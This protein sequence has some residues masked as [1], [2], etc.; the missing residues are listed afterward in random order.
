[1]WVRIPP[2]ALFDFLGWQV[3][4]YDRL[5]LG[6]ENTNDFFSKLRKP[7]FTKRLWKRI[8]SFFYHEQWIILLAK[9][10][11][12]RN[13]SWSDFTRIIPPPDRIWADPFI[14]TR[15][16]YYYIFFEEQPMDTKRGRICCL[17]LDNH[18]KIIANK[19]VLEQ[20][21]HLSYPF[22][23]EY[24]GL[25]YMLPETQENHTVE[26]Y[27]CVRFP[28]QWEKVKNLMTDIDAVDS[29]LFEANGKWWLFTN[30]AVDGG[31]TWDTL[32]LFYADNPLS[33]QW[34]PH[35]CNPIVK[36][37]HSA[38]PAGKI[39]S[40]S[41]GFIRP[42]QDCSVTY[43]Y[44]VN[45]NRINLLSETEYAETCESTFLPVPNNILAVHTWN[46]EGNLVAIDSILRHRKFF[47]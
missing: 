37:I 41:N 43:G 6:R 24:G 47:K 20:P 31:S 17:T 30:I 45:F 25:L 39:F 21:Y 7:N 10:V 26:I 15:E 38:R 32:H 28:A 13:P 42:S 4:F 3:T 11:L 9:D 2:G 16:G 44:A 8:R 34:T 1:L 23:F 12:D 35:P 5:T 29:T 22:I 18:L 40:D 27:R 36:D 14:W 33:E 19:I 46:K